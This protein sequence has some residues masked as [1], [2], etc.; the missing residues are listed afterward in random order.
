MQTLIAE[1]RDRCAQLAAEHSDLEAQN[2][3]LQGEV[4][5]KMQLLAEFEARFTSQYQ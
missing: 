3:A 5:D 1:L 2:Q 4:A